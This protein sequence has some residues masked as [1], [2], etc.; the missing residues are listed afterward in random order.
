MLKRLLVGLFGLASLTAFANL[1]TPIATALTGAGLSENALSVWVMPVT[2]NNNGVNGVPVL[3]HLP[4]TPRIPASTQK[5]IPTAIALDV[6]GDDFVWHNNVYHTGVLVHGVVYG[7]VVLV[8]SGDPAL[9]HEQLDKLL[10]ALH[11]KVSH[12]KGDIYIDT[13]RF[14]AVGYD[15]NAFDG[16]GE[17]AYNA[18]PSAFLVNF[19]TIE[20]KFTPQAYSQTA[21]VAILPKLSDV[22]VPSK[23]GVQAGC[24]LPK[25]HLSKTHLSKTNPPK[26]IAL[27]GQ[28]GVD[29]GTQSLWRN[30][31]NND[32]LAIQAV[33]YTWQTHDSTFAGQVKIGKPALPAHTVPLVSL[34]SKPLSAQ[35]K[36]INHF[37]NNV[38]TE[39]VA[40]SL[41]LYGKK[42]AKGYAKEQGDKLP[43]QL[44]SDYPQAFAFMN[45]WWQQHLPTPP[46]IMTRASGLCYDCAVSPKALGS[47][48]MFM[49]TH[50]HFESFWQ[51]LP[52]AGRTGTMASLAKR[53]PT[54]PAIDRAWL[55]TGTLNDVTAIAG[56]VKGKDDRLY[57]LVVMINAKNV[58]FNPKAI[59]VLDAVLA[60]TAER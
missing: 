47:L 8:G 31:G 24:Q 14:G 17:R 34:P 43:E 54:H 9:T 53:N 45:Q 49:T 25:A 22:T 21:D 18:E 4:D 26:H 1:P 6:L 37:S 48:L 7:D 23:I 40:L 38:M 46:P 16:Q 10:Q 19:G 11:D 51:S 12:I 20:L 30:F 28:F 39:Q 35:I 41:P 33:K 2:S 36:D 5:L 55:K 32:E 3:A 52:V 60:W 59:A 29:C 15:P 50:H 42:Y 57:V 58:G 56:Y 27:S 13:G 44:V